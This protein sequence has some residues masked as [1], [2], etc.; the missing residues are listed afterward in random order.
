MSDNDGT[1]FDKETAATGIPPIPLGIRHSPSNFEDRVP[2]I[3][4]AK[5]SKKGQEVWP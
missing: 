5:S 3:K 2:S 1:Y 4:L